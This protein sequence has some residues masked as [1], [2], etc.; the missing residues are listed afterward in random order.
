MFL[1][2]PMWLIVVVVATATAALGSS[3]A[4][5]MLRNRSAGAAR[6]ASSRQ[7]SSTSSR[8]QTATDSHERRLVLTFRKTR[9]CGKKRNAAG[10]D[11]EL[12]ARTVV[13]RHSLANSPSLLQELLEMD[14]EYAKFKEQLQAR[15]CPEL[16]TIT[17]LY[18]NQAITP[19]LAALAGRRA[20]CRLLE[21]N[22]GR[23]IDVSEAADTYH[24]ARHR[25][26]N[27]LQKI[28]SRASSS[29]ALRRLASL[30]SIQST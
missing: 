26:V 14:A 29:T 30:P 12:D 20:V 11:I 15:C 19:T 6:S 23:L 2:N 7:S 24:T 28:G 10:N 3:L 8:L 27:S 22:A 4:A 21:D 17:V 18:E 1:S 25:F 13:V 5:Y 16:G 9:R